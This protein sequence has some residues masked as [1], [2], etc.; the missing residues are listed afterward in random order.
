MLTQ[1]QRD[2]FRLALAALNNYS[3][4]RV[5]D[6]DIDQEITDSQVVETRDTLE[7]FFSAHGRK[8]GHR[9]GKPNGQEL[10][11]TIAGALYKWEAVQS[12]P[13]KRR[14]NLFVMDFGDARACYFDGEV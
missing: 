7:D 13:G 8:L 2:Q 9:D 10:C 3:I 6:L 12:R 14:G 4:K 5:A 11:R 1:Q